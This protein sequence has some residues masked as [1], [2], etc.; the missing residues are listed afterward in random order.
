M[1]QL[2]AICH[3]ARWFLSKPKENDAAH[4]YFFTKKN[5]SMFKS[6]PW[7]LRN[8]F[9]H[10]ITG[11]TKK[12]HVRYKL[13][14]AVLFSPPPPPSQDIFT[15]Y[16]HISNE[17]E[18]R[19][20]ATLT[21][22]LRLRASS[23]VLISMDGQVWYRC[24]QDIPFRRSSYMLKSTDLSEITKAKQKSAQITAPSVKWNKWTFF[25]QNHLCIF[26]VTFIT[27]S[28]ALSRFPFNLL[29]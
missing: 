19:R 17:I 15:L 16:V 2:V 18:V 9:S 21:N 8:I 22:R 20:S 11:K 1:H 28:T 23:W 29:R 24:R 4:F 3:I 27:L 5:H 14:Q 25:F 7:Q 13:L 10:T 6:P 26:P 12:S